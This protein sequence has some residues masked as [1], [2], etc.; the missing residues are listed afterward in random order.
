M[1]TYSIINKVYCEKAPKNKL[2]TA[3]KVVVGICAFI[4]IVSLMM[5]Q[6]ISGMNL[7][8]FALLLVNLGSLS[9]SKGGYQSVMADVIIS[10]SSLQI[11][12]KNLFENDNKNARNE[13]YVFEKEDIEKICYSEELISLCIIGKGYRRIEW[14]TKKYRPDTNLC[15]NKGYIYGTSDQIHDIMDTIG[16][17]LNIDIE[18]VR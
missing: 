9:P 5:G 14:L 15:V 17:E 2:N 8:V 11:V 1:K 6:G 16:K 4:I 10:D 7:G 12:D 13:Y 3:R 18:T